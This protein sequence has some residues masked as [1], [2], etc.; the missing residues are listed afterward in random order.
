[1]AE[2]VQ[3]VHIHTIEKRAARVMFGVID[4]MTGMIPRPY[5]AKGRKEMGRKAA[6]SRKAARK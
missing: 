2:V 3:K 5:W 6:D 1:M 4:K